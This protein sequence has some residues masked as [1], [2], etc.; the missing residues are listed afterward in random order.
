MCAKHVGVAGL[1]SAGRRSKS[2]IKNEAGWPDRW[3]RGRKNNW[4]KIRQKIREGK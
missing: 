2:I 4:I 1:N 3:I